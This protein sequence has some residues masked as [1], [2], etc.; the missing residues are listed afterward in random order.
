MATARIQHD[1]AIKPAVSSG[2]GVFP[3]RSRQATGVGSLHNPSVAPTKTVD[4]YLES[5]EDGFDT[6]DIKKKQVRMPYSALQSHYC[7]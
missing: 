3:L 1:D 5:E 7:G 4:D 6:R 2:G